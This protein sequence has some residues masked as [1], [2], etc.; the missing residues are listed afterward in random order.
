MSKQAEQ[1]EKMDQA[2]L[3]Q[4][5]IR[6]D[7]RIT[8]LSGKENNRYIIE[9]P[10]RNQFF[11]IGVREY[12][13]LCHLES[14]G[15][16]Q[17][18]GAEPDDT[19]E[20]LSREE[21]LTLLKWLAAKQLLKDQSPQT[22]QQIE[23]A[24]RKTR[25]RTNWLSRYNPIIFRVPLFNPDPYLSRLMPWLG[26]LAGPLFLALWLSLGIIAIALLLGNWNQFVHQSTA[27]FSAGNMVVIGI[28]WVVLKLLHELGHAVACSRHGGRVYEMG[29][30]FILFIPLT[31]VNA[32]SSWSFPTR[33]QR[34]QVGMAGMFMELFVAWCALLFWATHMASP[35][36]VIAHSTVLIAGVSSLLFNA[37]PL[38]R[39]DGYYILSDLV[40]VPN[41]YFHGLNATRHTIDKL[42]F[43]VSSSQQNAEVS[44]AIRLYGLAVYLWRILV[45]I[46][47]SVLACTLFGGWGLLLSVAALLGWSYQFGSTLTQKLAAYRQIQPGVAGQFALRCALLVALGLFVLFGLNYQKHLQAPAV[48]LFDQEHSIRAKISGFAEQILVREG[49]HV[50]TGQLLVV[51]A[52][53]DLTAQL[54]DSELQLDLAAQQ[55]RQAQAAGSFAGEQVLRGQIEVLQQRTQIL[56]SDIVQLHLTAPADGIV[57]G[58]FSDR[59]GTFIEKGE[60]LFQIVSPESKHLVASISQDDIASF[61]AAQAQEVEVDM[62]AAGL[63]TFTA[64]VDEISPGASTELGHFSL[65]AHFG[66]PLDVKEQSGSAGSGYEFF[67]PRFSINLTLPDA[68]RARLLVGQ[69]ATIRYR[70]VELPPAIHLWQSIKKWYRHKQNPA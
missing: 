2:P 54:R 16:L 22:M 11:R 41:L 29:I 47:L 43:G 27:F 12:R 10:L 49:E 50:Q 33:W 58:E 65:A 25:N 21:A 57:V 15:N 62:A 45:I 61:R 5:R 51:L 70:S 64:T 35:A 3:K 67:A 7:L 68:M 1:P 46:T 36:G 9:D 17:D 52:N 37:N 20:T 6:D 60:E 56:R 31:Y 8:P 69:Q 38:M 34:I 24:E 18:I 32:T 42:L 30:L 23:Q 40:R 44:L 26:W 28:I 53:D 19:D 63:G 66:G 59:I 4:P 39:F 48:V 13:F 55:L 14:G